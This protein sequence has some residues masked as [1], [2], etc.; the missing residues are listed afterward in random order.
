MKL[1]LETTAFNYFFDENRD[2]HEATVLLFEAIRTGVHEAYTSEYV[3]IELQAAE[4]PKRSAMLSLMN[5]YGITVLPL[6]EETDRLA[7]IYVEQG[8]IPVRF[9]FDAS[10]IACASINGLDYV[11]SYNFKHINRAKTKLLTERV[12]RAEG[13]GSVIICESKEVLNDERE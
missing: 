6:N 3:E 12:N 4:E 8:I 5:E 9:R 7:G 2:G 10:H 13:V 1:Y 11:V